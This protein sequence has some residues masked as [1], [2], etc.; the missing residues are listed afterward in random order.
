MFMRPILLVFLVYSALAIEID[1]VI[2]KPDGGSYY[3]FWVVYAGISIAMAVIVGVS[4]VIS[5]C[6]RYQLVANQDDEI[7]ESQW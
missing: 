2:E 4:T 7:S 5:M 6:R 1:F 3:R